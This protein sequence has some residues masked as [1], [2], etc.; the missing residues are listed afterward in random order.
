MKDRF[1]GKDILSIKDFSKEELLFLIEKSNVVKKNHPGF[2]L[3][4]KLMGSCF[5]EP[6]TRTR[7]SFEAAMKRLGG[8]VIGFS[9]PNTTSSKKG[10]SLY[11]T[12]KVIGSY[13]DLVVVRHPHEGAA[14]Q[15]SEAT[16]KPVINAG[17]GANE[18][19]TQTLLDLF[20]IKESQGRLEGLNIVFAGDLKYGRTVHSLALAFKH[21]DCRIFFVSP[22][23][24]T[25]PETICKDLKEAGIPFSFHQTLEEVIKRADI[26]YM[27]RIQEERFADRLEYQLVKNSFVVTPEL[28]SKGK[29][30][31][32]VLHPLP[33][34]GEIT[35]ECDQTPQAYYFVQSE[36]GLY[37]RQALLM[38]VL[39][40]I[41]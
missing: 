18:H 30:T 15:A 4:G 33:R 9:E 16:D 22:Q 25:M 13:S 38:L 19:P 23:A 31:L 32:R 1:K 34:V 26:L 41:D 37:V 12:I 3:K 14:R 40:G 6:S 28:L 17:D 10:E 21:F 39:N 8:D 5:F 11:D 7:L 27:T 29:K 35:L 36:N 24:L 20:T 2:V